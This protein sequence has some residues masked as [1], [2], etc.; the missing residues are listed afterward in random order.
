M[1]PS[2]TLVRIWIAYVHTDECCVFNT[3][4]ELHRPGN[5]PSL[6]ITSKEFTNI[7]NM[8]T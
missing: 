8:E 5:I 6:F 4:V 1:P 3:F 7:N 2:E